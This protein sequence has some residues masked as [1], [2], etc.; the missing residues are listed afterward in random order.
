M[1]RSMTWCSIVFGRGGA[2]ITP[3]RSSMTCFYE[4]ISVIAFAFVFDCSPGVSRPYCIH[5]SSVSVCNP[6]H[7]MNPRVV[8]QVGWLAIAALVSAAHTT[9]VPTLLHITCTILSIDAVHN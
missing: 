1:V 7:I 9:S 2:E 5:N 8:L 4:P 6:Y 3:L